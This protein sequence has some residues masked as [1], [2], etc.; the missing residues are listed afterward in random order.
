MYPSD[1]LLLDRIVKA[2][3]NINRPR[4]VGGCEVVFTGAGIA[5]IIP[6]TKLVLNGQVGRGIVGQVYFF[7]TVFVYDQERVESAD[8]YISF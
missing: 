2:F 6:N 5:I 4:Q 7:C 1:V 3:V 8:G